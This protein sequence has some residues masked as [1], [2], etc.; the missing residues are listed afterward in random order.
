MV[1]L[2]SV[3]SLFT[4]GYRSFLAMEAVMTST[5]RPH[6]RLQ[7]LIVH[8]VEPPPPGVRRIIPEVLVQMF[9]REANAQSFGSAEAWTK[10]SAREELTQ[11]MNLAVRRP[12]GSRRIC[13]V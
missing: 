4:E 7:P 5:S 11:Q 12:F 13:C 1:F 3:E 2:D 6:L 10:E 9:F 8:A